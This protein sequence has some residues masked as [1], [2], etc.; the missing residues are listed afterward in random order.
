MTTYREA[1]ERLTRK[2][3]PEHP[4][5]GITMA[6]LGDELRKAGKF[7]ESERNLRGGLD[8]LVK[9]SGEDGPLTQA[10]LQWLANLYA[11]WKKPELAAA[12]KA[13]VK[14]SK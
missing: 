1:V 12:Y 10:T 9:A 2:L 8:I 7:A 13:R 11:D 5:V 6:A 4:D 3:G 14:T